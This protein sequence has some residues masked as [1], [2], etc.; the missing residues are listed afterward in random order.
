MALPDCEV[1]VI[2]F[3]IC[4]NSLTLLGTLKSKNPR[5]Y[6]QSAGNLYTK[7]FSLKSFSETTCE[8]SFNFSLF[9][10]HAT[11]ALLPSD[12]WLTWFIGFSEGD[13]AILNSKNRLRFILTQKERAILDHIQET[14]GFGT[15]R[16]FPRFSRFVVED[17]A[18]IEL[19]LYLFNGNLVLAYRQ[20]QLARWI[21]LSNQETVAAISTLVLPTL[22]DSWLSGFTD[23]EGCFNV[24]ITKRPDTVTGYRVVLRF[25]LDQKNAFNLLNYISSLFGYGQVSIRNNTDMVYRYSSNSL[26]GLLTVR[27]YFISYP[28]KTDKRLSFDRWSIVYEMVLNKEHLTREGLDKISL[29]AKTININNSLNT[30][31]GSA[32]PSGPSA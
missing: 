25:L 7:W 18:S 20:S 6:T 22:S 28:L 16:E 5:S 11:T 29:I 17:K 15:V 32:H 3:A 21:E 12:D 1:G 26:A 13:G 24:Q 27:D 8:T 9:K 2:N 30:K 31:T 4:W 14:L 23:A 19:L 10:K